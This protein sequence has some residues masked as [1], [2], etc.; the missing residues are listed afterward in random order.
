MQLE[1]GIDNHTLSRLITNFPKKDDAY[2]TKNEFQEM[3][4]Q[5]LE[6]SDYDQ[7]TRLRKVLTMFAYAEEFRWWPPP[8]FSSTMILLFI[9]MFVYHVCYLY[10][11]TGFYYKL[12]KCS[13]WILSLIHI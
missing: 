13:K 12:A 10:S 7:M 8:L 9:A 11:I 1:G 3:M 6:N 5:F 4:K 2:M